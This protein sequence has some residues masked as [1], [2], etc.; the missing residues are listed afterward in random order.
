MST[1]LE[2]ALEAVKAAER[3]IMGY[4]D[5]SLDVEKK[6]DDSPVT[7]ADKEA[8]NKIREVILAAFPD[9]TVYGEEG[10]KDIGPEDSYTWVVDPIDGT[11]SFIRHHGLFGTLLALYHKGEIIVG[12]SNMPAIG[13]L[14]Y[15]EKGKGA[16]LNKSRVT[17][18][19]VGSL[20]DAYMSY[21]SVKY[22]TQVGKQDALLGLA[23]QTR[24]ARGIGDC[25]S[26]HLLAQGKLDIVAEA[27]TK[28]WDVAAL[29][30][31]VEE[32][33][34]RMSTLSGG[35]IDFSLTDDVATNGRLHDE[36]VAAFK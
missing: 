11:K 4:Y 34:G 30:V 26:Y 33:G 23:E 18:S 9:H 27:K 19:D 16:Y 7:I 21:G 2:V 20:K 17:V 35:V 8:E 32:A 13:E 28:I 10:A 31:I 22:F 15:A 24:W 5:T 3:I 29:K 36:V 14:M 6:T 12:V 1:Y 25:W